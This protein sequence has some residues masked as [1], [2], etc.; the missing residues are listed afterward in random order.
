MVWQSD[1]EVPKL[2]ETHKHWFVQGPQKPGTG[3][4]FLVFPHESRIQVCLLIRST[5]HSTALGAAELPFIL[6]A[7][8]ATG[9]LL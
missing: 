4:V 8:N 1:S 2:N 3:P 6:F 7:E 9:T 5:G